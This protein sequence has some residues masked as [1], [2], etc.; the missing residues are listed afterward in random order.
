MLKFFG[1]FFPSTF[2][3]S[4]DSSSRNNYMSESKSWR[5]YYV[6]PGMF[7]I[8]SKDF[9][10]LV[11]SVILLLS[12][13]CYQDRIAEPFESGVAVR[14]ITPPVGFPYYGLNSST[15]VKSPL[16][17][18]AL[19]FTQG[20]VSCALLMC[21]L[22]VIPRDLSRIV[23]EHAS[24]QTGIPFSN[25]T[26]TATH[27]HTGPFYDS[28]VT[29]SH[30][31]AEHELAGR[32]TE[33]DE[34]SYI[35]T[36]IDE[37]TKAIVS[38]NKNLHITEMTSGKGKAKGISFNRRYL[39]TDGRVR[40]N[41]GYLN[42]GIVRPAGPVDPDV[43]FVMFRP[44]D[45]PQFTHSLTV[46]ANHTDTEGGS[47]FSADY[48]HFLQLRL[49]EIFGE[50]IISVF[51]LG[52]CGNVNHIDVRKPAE[53]TMRGMIT[54]KIGKTLAAAV[55]SAFQYGKRSRPSLEVVSKT[56]FFPLQDITCEELRWAR[57][58]TGQ[59]YPERPFMTGMRRWKILDIDQMR[60]W[61]AVPPSVSGEPWRLPVE[62]QVFRLDDRTAIVTMP[63]EI[64]V[65]HGIELKKRSPFEN[66]M[67]IE[68][69]NAWI[70]Y[71]PTKAAF[72]EGDYEALNS[73][74][75]PGS[76]EKLVEEALKLLN[77]LK[78]R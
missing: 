32:I 58:G 51:G 4:S 48:P 5:D 7:F 20:N 9:A 65:E 61:E 41:P 35:G 50:Q 42:P 29:M 63:G 1:F 59:F 34:K 67:L 12:P 69:A 73:R 77:E 33:E 70:K 54:E 6:S 2:H 43:H 64:F 26:V 39:M 53:A 15:G 38:A 45:R 78:E 62:I 31:Y 57:E 71:V 19:V 55:D 3:S 76:G 49:K 52:P 60:R 13:G 68:L 18:K 25:I 74:L 24:K 28:L 27:I 11:L 22:S 37:M 47:E 40:F 75:M 44:A 10:L 14:E 23:R 46:F 21:D 66:T 30:R 16:H 36:L 56:V 8:C 72:T 17:A